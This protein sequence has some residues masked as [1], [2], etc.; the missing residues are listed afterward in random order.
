[1]SQER[2]P[3]L[4]NGSV[5]TSVARRWLSSRHA[6]DEADMHATTEEL[7]EAV[8][9]VQS[10]LRLYIMRPAVIRSQSAERESAGSQSVGGCSS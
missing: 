5:N 10:I 4:R 7:L 1:V 9:S 3:L 2:Q 6:I 8:L